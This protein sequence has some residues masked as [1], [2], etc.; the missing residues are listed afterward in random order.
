MTAAGAAAA[1]ARDR[2]LRLDVFRG[3]AMCIILVAHIPEN[4]WALWI[5]ARFGFSDATEMFVFCSGM[6]SAIAFGSTF[7]AR[8]WVLGTARIA[9]R[10][11]QVYWAHVGLV[12][13]TLALL[14]LV[15]RAGLGLPGKTYVATLPVVPFFERTAEALLGLLSLTWV[16][17]YFDILPMYLVI[18]ALVPAVMALHAAAGRGAVAALVLGLWLLAQTGRLDLPAR[19][20]NAE[21]TWFFNPF[22]WQLVFFAGFALGM[23]WLRPPRPTRLRIRLALGFLLLSVPFAW[24]RLHEGFWLPAG[25]AL[26]LFLAETRALAEPLIWKTWFGA[27]RFVHFLALAWLAWVAVGPG[28][29]RLRTGW[30]SDWAPSARL[31]WAAALAALLT[32]PWAWAKEIAIHWPALDALILHHFTVTAGALL[33]TGL[34]VAPEKLGMIQLLHLAALLVLAWAAIGAARRRAFFREGFLAL[35]PQLRRIGQQS[36][37]VFVVSM[38][39]AQA[40]GILLDHLGRAMWSF[41]LVNLSGIMILVGVAGVAAWFKAQPWRKPQPE[42]SGRARS[43]GPS[44]A[45]ADASGRAAAA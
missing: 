42:R 18:L 20:W 12:L 5:P 40:C 11:W 26:H 25:G 4:K 3:L 16:P 6:A 23:G 35:V 1:P 31:Q 38:V 10:I 33:G 32:I 14:A 39:L 19:P 41:A 30:V 7:A 8:G 17:N 2:D 15:D 28:G 29:L 37:A 13:A 27:L 9:W 45:A 21:A 36:L 22:G 43:P 34:L 24:F 44:P